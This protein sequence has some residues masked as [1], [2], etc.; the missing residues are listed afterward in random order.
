M[1]MAFRAAGNGR[2]FFPLRINA[3]PAASPAALPALLAAILAAALSAALLGAAPAAAQDLNLSGLRDFEGGGAGVGTLGFLKLPASARGIGMGAASRTTDEEATLVRGNP[4]LLALVGDYYYSIS[5]TEVLGEFRHEDLAFT[6][7][8]LRWGNFGGSANI[9]AATAFEGARD[10]DENPSRP[11]AYDAALG[12]SYGLPLWQDRVDAGARLDLIHSELDGAAAN[13]YSVSLGTLF[14]LVSNLR[15]AFTL[16]NLSHGIRYD[17]HSGAPYEPLPLAF[18]AE[19]GR[20]MLDGRWSGQIGAAQGNDGITRVYGGA[21]WRMLKYLLLRAGYDGSV[22]DRALGPWSGISAGLGIKYDRITLDYGYR[23]MGALGAYHSFTLNYSRKSHFR[24]RDELFLEQAEEKF[25]RGNYRAALSFA[26]GA[27]ALNPYNF[28]AQALAQKAALE[29]ERLNEMAVTLAYTGNTEGR[30][31][32]EWRE[33]KPMGGLPRRKTKLQEMKSADGKILILDAGNLTR[34]GAGLDKSEYVYGAYAQMPYDAL[35]VGAAEARLGAERLDARLPFLASQK[36]LEGMAPLLAEKRLQLKHGN[37]I[38][39]L[40]AASAQGLKAGAMGGKELE[41]AADAVRR[42]AGPPRENRILV[43]LLH[44][45][46]PEARALALQVPGIDVI[47]LSGEAMA[48]PAPMLAGKTLLCSPGMGGT[49]VGE[50]T[51]R[52]DKRGHLV[53]Y[54]HFLLPL[55]ASV[56]EDPALKK[57]LEPVTVDPNKLSFDDADDDYRAQ[58]IAYIRT[59][60]PA[61]PGSEAKGGRLFLRDLRAGADYEVPAAGLLCSRPILG[62]GKNRVAFAG[63]DAAGAREVYA[64]EPG[65]ARLDTLTRLGGR[66]GELHWFL[67]NNAVL[68]VY[69]RDGKSDL[70]RI[71]PWSKEVRDLTKGRFGEVSGFDI[72]RDG[73][74]LALCGKE[75]QAAAAQSATLW[76]TNADLQTPIA[77]ANE[78]GMLGSPR[79]NPAGDKLA[80]LSANAPDSGSGAAASGELRIF[81][82]ATKGLVNATAQSRVRSFAWSDD[83]KR[84]FYSAGVNLADLNAYNVDS[85]SLTKVTRAAHAPRS[86]ENPTPK[87]L[88][89]RDGLLFEAVSDGGRR[90]LWM[91]TKTG[92]ERTLADSAGSNSLK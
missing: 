2:A 52:L 30:L 51:L 37:E 57:F 67:R 73:G 53:S 71:D 60:A 42:R 72:S 44:A 47:I 59:E 84:I 23:A 76:V 12:I 89:D 77:I 8:T 50:L 78:R 1:S 41:S 68:A 91:D 39:V 75:P 17:D 45:G 3:A 4:A 70:Y 74:R 86:E 65:I 35:N 85:I 55:D 49:H 14:F 34:P 58:V 54:R 18:G 25:R 33:G 69:A 16:D 92:E 87:L 27:I 64:F 5:H 66:A 10:I 38:L 11:S 88:G 62:Y 36:P 32:S 46:L 48:L 13:G 24:P 63:Q 7:P 80:W 40:G 90:L 43:L 56:P 19:L 79:W 20:P 9:L 29:M 61:P 82:F 31:A 83:G 81:D 26:R 21:E 22:Q 28:K 6:Y 15:L